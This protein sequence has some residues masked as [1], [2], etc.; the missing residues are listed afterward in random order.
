[1]YDRRPAAR[2]GGAALDL[3]QQ[4]G[5]VQRPTAP[6]QAQLRLDDHVALAPGAGDRVGGRGIE[7]DDDQG[8]ASSELISAGHYFTRKTVVPTV[9]LP[10]TNRR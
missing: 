5:R 3:G 9:F 4:S 7:A 10:L 8:I 6:V 2:R 1:M